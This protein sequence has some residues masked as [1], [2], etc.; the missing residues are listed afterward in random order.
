[1]M[2]VFKTFGTDKS[3]EQKGVWI[4]YDDTRFLIARAGGS[5]HEYRTIFTS[6]TKPYR[7]QIEKGTLA[8]S[9]QEK[10]TAE[11]FA[12]AIIK[13]VQVRK[14]KDSAWQ[15]G[16][17]TESGEVLELTNENVV[18]LLLA[19]PELFKDIVSCANDIQFF[20]KA[21]TEADVKNSKKS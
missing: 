19:L 6:K 9:E 20:A 7:H 3:A 1:M 12:E 5:N 15:D 14:D 8:Q 13:K 17:P 10:L 11:I 21:E 4:T 2:S 16:V 18:N